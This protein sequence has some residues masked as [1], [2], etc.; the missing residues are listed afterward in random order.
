MRRTF[1]LALGATLLLAA[2]PRGEQQARQP[3]TEADRL[4]GTW[5]L[6][7][8]EIN[9]NPIPLDSLKE[10]NAPVVGRLVVKGKS[11]SFRMGKT[12]LELAYHLRPGERPRA[13]D[14]TLT[15]GPQK[16]QTY[17]GIYRLRGN[18][19]TVCRPVEPGKSRP[20]AFATS[21]DS[22]LMLVVWKRVPAR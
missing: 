4:Q 22:G 16:G 11:Y 7:S 10:D 6:F 19:Y 17:Y 3:R 8:V 13:I 14:L 15:D 21:P 5:Q 2:A 12:R 1:L 20:T 18:T 9:H